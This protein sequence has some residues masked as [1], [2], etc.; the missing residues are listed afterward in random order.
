[1]PIA[2]KDRNIIGNK[3]IFGRF[4]LP[5][6]RQAGVFPTCGRQASSVPI[7]KENK[8]TD[9]IADIHIS[10]YV[11]PYRCT[12]RS[13]RNIDLELDRIPFPM[14]IGIRGGWRDLRNQKSFYLATLAVGRKGKNLIGA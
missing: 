8:A 14:V 11:Y 3:L 7:S 5:C 2:K 6:L 4:G 1:L 9:V 12:F 13:K 10:N